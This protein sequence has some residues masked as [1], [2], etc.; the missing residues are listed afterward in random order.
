[1]LITGL[2][3]PGPAY[4]F[5]RHNLGFRVADLIAERLSIS[6]NRTCWQGVSG[7]GMIR[8][9]RIT[10]LKPLT[11]MNLSGQSVRRALEAMGEGPA[12]L[13]VLHDDMDLEFGRLRIRLRG[14]SGGHRGVQ[15]IIDSL[16][17]EEF[18]RLKL[19]VGR[20]PEG[21]DPVDY[22]LTPFS[23]AEEE[24]MAALLDAAVGAVAAIIDL[25]YEAAI[26]RHN[27]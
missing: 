12:D 23:V 2:G 18:P 20:P 21:I 14:S 10:I 15:S 4:R 9:Q 16:G 1:M 13:L 7:S 11:Y 8:G 27:S 19:G 25:G 6:L 5:T 22:V 24:A 3:N 26:S 17:T